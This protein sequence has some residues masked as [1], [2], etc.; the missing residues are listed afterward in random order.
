MDKNVWMI[1]NEK[2]E[3]HVFTIFAI[4]NVMEFEYTLR[5]ERLCALSLNVKIVSVLAYRCLLLYRL[6]WN[7]G[8]L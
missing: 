2:I 4:G 6:D 1:C 3:H 7:C 5:S 8:Q